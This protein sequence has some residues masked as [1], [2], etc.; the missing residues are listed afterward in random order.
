M[1]DRKH[2]DVLNKKSIQLK[3]IVS[4]QI[5][6]LGYR[7][8]CGVSSLRNTVT[9]NL[10]EYCIGVRITPKQKS[11]YPVPQD[12]Q[13]KI[14]EILKSEGKDLKLNIQYMPRNHSKIFDEYRVRAC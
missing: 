1:T 14:E 5:D 6:S 7:I 11:A 13:S 4:Q 12:I 2:I 9:G 3:N 10:E 8:V